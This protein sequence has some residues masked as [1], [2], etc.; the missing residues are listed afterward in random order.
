MYLHYKKENPLLVKN[1]GT[2][3]VLPKVMKILER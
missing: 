1:Y 2:V 3:S